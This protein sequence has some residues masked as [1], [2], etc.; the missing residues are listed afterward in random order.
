M[1]AKQIIVRC[2]REAGLIRAADQVRLYAELARMRKRRAAFRR[3]NPSFRLPPVALAYDAFGSLDPDGYQTLGLH[4]AKLIAGLIQKYLPAPGRI[5]D[6]GCGPVRILRHM[7]DLFPAGT[8][9][10]G[11]DFNRDTITWCRAN[12]SNIDFR[13]NDLRPPLPLDSGSVDALY[14]ISVF[15]HLSEE[16]HF[17]YA[18]ELQ[19]VLR[20]GGL[21]IATAH[22]DR[23]RDRLLPD[24]ARRYDAGELVCRGKTQE[25]KRMFASF[26]SPSFMRQRLFRQFDVLEHDFSSSATGFHQDDWVAR[27]KS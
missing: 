9:L 21:V 12:F 15:T 8:Q 16:M 1:A 24:E 4:H 2:L 22:G 26:H 17:A 19:R 5:C 13:Q 14:C 11:L 25:G 27:S 18:E 10:V 20:P 6:W 23:Y 3:A 7:P